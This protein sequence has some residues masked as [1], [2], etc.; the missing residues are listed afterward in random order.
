[1]KQVQSLPNIACL[2]RCNQSQKKKVEKRALPDSSMNHVVEQIRK[3]DDT[4]GV[5]QADLVAVC[6]PGNKFL[7]A[8][9]CRLASV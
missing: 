1:M 6:E 9:G 8:T 3:N 7:N 2:L 4:I 5:R